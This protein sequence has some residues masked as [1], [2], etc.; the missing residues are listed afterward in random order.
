M[1][2]KSAYTHT[3]SLW[4]LF[5]EVLY[6]YQNSLHPYYGIIKMHFT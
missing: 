3:L 2:K 5:F 1:E 4:F 6:I